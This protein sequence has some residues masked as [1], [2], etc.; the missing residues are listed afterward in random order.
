MIDWLLAPLGYPFILRGLVA[1]VVV[2]AVCGVVGS[3]AVL[4]RMSY[5]GTALSHS[6]LPGVALGYLVS[7]VSRGPLFW[8]GAGTAAAAGLA[9]AALS[10]R[11][12]VTEDA[13]VGIVYAGL[14][15][16]GIV[17]VST[18]RGFAVDL[19]HFLFGSL[20]TVSVS[21][22]VIVIAGALLIGAL[23]IVF[24][25]QLVLVTFDRVFAASVRVRSGAI[26]YLLYLLMALATALAL[27]TIGVALVV[28]LMVAPAAA[29]I[30]I[31]RRFHHTMLMAAAI[32][33]AS[34]VVGVYGSYYG[35]VPPGAAVALACVLLFGAVASATGLV[36]RLQRAGD[37]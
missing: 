25:R 16:L 4:R 7:G 20:L 17:I 18:V 32:G 30:P 3:F 15:A 33:A 9:M 2:A 5:I 8:W 36:R 1:V 26:T 31:T 13:A 37:G 28:T 11:G 6:L 29:A 12:R 34:G 23:V 21:D 24:Y 10:R 14:F 19:M 35:D 22:V 27:Q